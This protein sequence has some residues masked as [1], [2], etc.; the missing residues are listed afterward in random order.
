V[1]FPLVYSQK[2]LTEK[3]IKTDHLDQKRLSGKDSRKKGV[4]AMTDGPTADGL[5]NYL[6]YMV[7]GLVSLVFGTIQK[8]FNNRLKKVEETSEKHTGALHAIEL[9]IGDKFAEH[10]RDELG[11]RES[12]RSEVKSDFAELNK[13]VESGHKEILKEIRS[14]K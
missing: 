2:N 4:R 7:V 8:T 6:I 5:V 9:K 1:E 10:E 11:W 3:L 14:H 12:H 13:K